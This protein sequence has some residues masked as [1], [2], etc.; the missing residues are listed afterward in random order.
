[1]RAS[2]VGDERVSVDWETAY[3]AHAY[4]LAFYL[5]RLVGD[6]EVGRDLMQESF[7][8][9]LR[10]R[11]DIRDPRAWLYRVATNLAMSY[12][13]R[14]RILA[15]VPFASDVPGRSSSVSDEAEHVRVA[16]R[17]IPPAQAASLLLFYESGFSRAEVAEL[18]DLSEETVKTRL[19]RGRKN[20]IA[21]Y[22]RLE[23]GLAR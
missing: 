1:M 12:R 6:V 17:A 5:A 14:K 10:A 20:F 9:G 3:K 22:R 13:R 15:F 8:L 7:L 18:L 19:A 2:I 23:R 16:L 4:E 11:D 21:A